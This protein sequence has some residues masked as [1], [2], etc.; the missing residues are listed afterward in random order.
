MSDI[1]PTEADLAIDLESLLHY[2]K[3]PG[4]RKIL[5]AITRR[6]IAA[7]EQ[8]DAYRKLAEVLDAFPLDDPR[9]ESRAAARAAVD[10]LEKSDEV[11]THDRS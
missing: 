2:Q 8:R 9:G 6:C 4:S 5:T 3:L 1:K 11:Q 10:A 7:E